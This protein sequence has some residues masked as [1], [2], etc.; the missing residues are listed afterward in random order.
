MWTCTGRARWVPPAREG[1]RHE[2]SWNRKHNGVRKSS[3]GCFRPWSWSPSLLELLFS[4]FSKVRF[5][6]HPPQ[7]RLLRSE[8]SRFV[9]SLGCKEGASSF[10][11]S[12]TLSRVTTVKGLEVSSRNLG[13]FPLE[14][15]TR[16]VDYTQECGLLRHE[17]T[18][19]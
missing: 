5:P 18:I 2:K 11:S 19:S 4:L 15:H 14:G 10:R 9:S 17:T 6:G 3:S 7:S 16:S 12:A 8:S 13:S 1:S